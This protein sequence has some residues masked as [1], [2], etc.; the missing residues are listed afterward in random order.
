MNPPAVFVRALL[1]A[2]LAYF[3]AQAGL[4]LDFRAYF[5]SLGGSLGYFGNSN[6]N[7]AEVSPPNDAATSG[8]R[9]RAGPYQERMALYRRRYDYRPAAPRT[10]SSTTEQALDPKNASDVCGAGP[11]YAR[12]FQR[13]GIADGRSVNDEDKRLFDAFF[14]AR[15]PEFKGTFVE[16]GAFNGIRESNSLFFEHCLGWEGVLVEGNPAQWPRLVANRPHAHRLHYAPSCN[17]TD[18]AANATV[19]FYPSAFTNAGLARDDVRSDYARQELLRPVP[20]PCGTLTGVLRDLLPGSGRVSVF[21]LDVEGAEP[22]VVGNAISFEEVFIE[23]LMVEQYNQQCPAPPKPCA[24]RE[25]VRSIMKE[26]G[27]ALHDKLVKKSDVYVHP[28]SDFQ[29][30]FTA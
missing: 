25:K 6:N 7:S 9:D 1:L 13:N 14:R 26:R 2:S 16:M 23:V 8:G 3:F 21:S 18:E 28:L 12:W 11:E 29:V 4:V 24:S 5:A 17:A 30:P 27:Y 15:G 19:L 10:H 20:V 22:L